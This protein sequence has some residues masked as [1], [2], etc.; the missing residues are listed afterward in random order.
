MNQE[1]LSWAEMIK[2]EF[3]EKTLNCEDKDAHNWIIVKDQGEHCG[4]SEDQ[5][6]Q[7]FKGQNDKPRVEY[8]V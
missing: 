3:L 4:V 5:P 2:N 8:T 1:N 7:Y 6:E